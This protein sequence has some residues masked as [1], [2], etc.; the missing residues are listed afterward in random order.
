M[1]A[2]RYILVKVREPQASFPGKPVVVNGTMVLPHTNFAKIRKAIHE[3]SQEQFISVADICS[4][5]AY[6]TDDETQ[7]LEDIFNRVM[8]R[9]KPNKKG[10][11]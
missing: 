5:S 9:C 6:M 7:Q 4:H 10:N 8:A 3:K 2:D 1:V 11:K